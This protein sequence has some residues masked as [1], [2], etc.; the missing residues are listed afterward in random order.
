MILCVG[1]PEH[2]PEGRYSSSEFDA[3]MDALLN[4][5]SVSPVAHKISAAGRTVL[6]GEGRLAR[7]TAEQV[8]MPTPIQEESLLNEIP[9]RSYIDD[10]KPLPLEKWMKKAARQR[11]AADPRQ[12]ESHAEVVARADRLIEKLE[13][14]CPNVLLITYPLFLIELLDR[15]RAHNYVV[16]RSG[17]FRAEPLEKVVVSRKDEHCGGCQHNCFLSNPGCGIGRDKAN[18]QRNRK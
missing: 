7:S 10:G 18:R 17:L 1:L 6:I 15:F 12:P 8:L 16:Q 4:S 2:V 13:T 5:E 9:V 14:E 11:K 3:A